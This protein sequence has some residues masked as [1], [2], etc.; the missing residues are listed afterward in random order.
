MITVKNAENYLKDK[1][2]EEAEDIK[3][4]W[5]TFKVAIFIKI[6]ARLVNR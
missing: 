2:G 5:E 4:V 6:T 3:K 1:I